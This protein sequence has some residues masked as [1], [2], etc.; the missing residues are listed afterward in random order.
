M[1]ETR[2]DTF[3]VDEIHDEINNNQ[4]NVIVFRKNLDCR[5]NLLKN[6]TQDFINNLNII[7]I[8][9]NKLMFNDGYEIILK[10]LNND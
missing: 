9:D 10:I 8:K 6:I 3:H 4:Y 2:D 1:M 7:G 5:S